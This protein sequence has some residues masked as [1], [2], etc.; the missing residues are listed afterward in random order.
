MFG[1]REN[2]KENERKGEK[3]AAA[4]LPPVYSQREVSS[5]QTVADIC[6]ES[7]EITKETK[8]G[9]YYKG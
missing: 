5:V 8:I 3:E 7:R 1:S 4:K 2:G 6:S 9:S